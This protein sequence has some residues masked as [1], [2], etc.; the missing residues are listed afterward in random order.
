MENTKHLAEYLFNPIRQEQVFS[1]AWDSVAGL[2][3]NPGGE[4][5]EKFQKAITKLIDHIE[6][7]KYGPFPTL[8]DEENDQLKILSEK[9]FEKRTSKDHCW[10]VDVGLPENEMELYKKLQAKVYGTE[11]P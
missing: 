4:S 11:W 2:Q 7:T 6:A 5:E 10:T 3:N 1:D 9:R 8:T